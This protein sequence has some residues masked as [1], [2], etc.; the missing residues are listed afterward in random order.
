LLSKESRRSSIGHFPH[1]LKPVHRFPGINTLDVILNHK[2]AVVV[3][4][5]GLYQYDYQDLENVEILSKIPTK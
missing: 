5:D 4:K 2:M 1:N 3:G